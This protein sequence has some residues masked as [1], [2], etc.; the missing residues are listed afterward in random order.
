M[1]TMA[2][3]SIDAAGLAPSRDVERGRWIGRHGFESVEERTACVGYI[4]LRSFHGS[5]AARCTAI[6]AI[7]RLSG[8]AS[9][10]LDLRRNRGGDESMAALL[11][12]LLFDTEGVHADAVY[13][14]SAG[15]PPSP[16]EP[17]LARQRVEVL[18]S[19]ET[20]PLALAFAT[21]LSRLGR[22][23]VRVLPALSIGLPDPTD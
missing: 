18:V 1:S 22:A 13:V 8:M 4:E 6:D 21:N 23:T 19:P 3:A 20:S 5:P 12:S 7:D 9:L 11:T 15:L 16:A 10:V 14:P 2:I 17:R